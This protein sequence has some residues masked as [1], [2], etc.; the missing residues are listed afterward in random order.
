MNP[1]RIL[2]VHAKNI[3]VVIRI[4]KTHQM[5]FFPNRDPREIVDLNRTDRFT[6]HRLIQIERV[7]DPVCITAVVHMPIHIDIRKRCG[8]CHHHTWICTRFKQ[9]QIFGNGDFFGIER[10]Q[11]RSLFRVFRMSRLQISQVICRSFMP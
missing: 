11:K 8:F 4:I 3:C 5:D 9:H 6:L 1:C 10:R 2:C 7:Q